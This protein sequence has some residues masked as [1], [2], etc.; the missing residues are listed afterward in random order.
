MEND[1]LVVIGGDAGGMTAAS[2]V[3]RMHPGRKIVVFERGH[4]TSYASCGL[5]YYIAGMVDDPQSMVARTPEEFR[6]KYDIDVRMRHEVVS[7]DTKA[8]QLQV[9]HLE[10]DT[11]FREP[12]DQLLIATGAS[13]VWPGVDGVEAKGI[14]ALSV[15]QSGIEVFEYMDA[16]SPRRAVIVGGGYIGLEMAEALLERGLEVSLLDMAPQVMG[17]LD[18]EMAEI[19]SKYMAEQ[20]ISLYLDESLK[21]FE[22][23]NGRVSAVVTAK[24][25]LGADLVILGMGIKPNS[26]LAGQAGIALGASQAIRVNRQQQTSVP[27]V[28]AAGDCA[29]SIHR[30]SGHEVHVALGTVANK[31]GLVAGKNLA[32]EQAGF[33]G[34][35]GTAITRIKALEV[36]RTGLNEKE[37]KALDIPFKT[38][39]ISATTRSAYF[40]GTGDITVKLL[41]HRDDGRLL[42]GQI[43]GYNGAA[44]RIDTIIAAITAGMTARDLMYLDLSYAPPFSPVWDPVQVA[45][46]KLV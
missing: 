25:T 1:K 46:R 3:R 9:R 37:L 4:H 29:T 22:Q 36:A 45:A 26:A 35:C 19:V 40:P 39:T 30:V 18:A 16:A 12:Y 34:V 2:L 32:G 7:I 11:I 24:R 27:N 41:A 6:E 38:E 15:L 20:G 42:G 31:Q 8:Q 43:V 33:P 23:R 10:S 13:P 14:F 21:H 44:K 17:T 5:P 28:W